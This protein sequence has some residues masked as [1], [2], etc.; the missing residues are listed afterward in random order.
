MPTR[1]K[2]SCTLHKISGFGRP[3]S[4]STDFQMLV[5]ALQ[6]QVRLWGASLGSG[7]AWISSARPGPARLGSAP[8]GST[9]GC[10]TLPPLVSAELGSALFTL[11]QLS[12]A[13]IGLTALSRLRGEGWTRKKNVDPVWPFCSSAMPAHKRLP[14]GV[15]K[16]ILV[17][18][19][20]A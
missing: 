7:S 13:W 16:K 19:G 8:L 17:V 12:V 3:F 2:Y 11:A 6:W 14:L 18:I 5:G 9:L 1:P 4:D 15:Q 10:L 20:W